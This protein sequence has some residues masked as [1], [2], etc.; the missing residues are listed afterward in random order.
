MAYRVLTPS[1]GQMTGL[2]ATLQHAIP[3]L[4]TLRYLSKARAAWP[5]LDACLVALTEAHLIDGGSRR[6]Q[7]LP[8]SLI[9]DTCP[10]PD[11]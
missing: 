9:L 4:Q 2:M 8:M 11:V 1:T 5:C 7:R 6:S 10:P 3:Q